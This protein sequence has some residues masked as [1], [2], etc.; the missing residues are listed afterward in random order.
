MDAAR[1]V[2]R[3]SFA[4]LWRLAEN[5]ESE[6]GIFEV[7]RLRALFN[8][9]LVLFTAALVC[10]SNCA[11]ARP[12]SLNAKLAHT[13]AMSHDLFRFDSPASVASWS[14]VDDRV[15]G[16][17]SQSRMRFDSIADA[18]GHA[19]FDGVVS[20]ER[21]G[22]FASVRASTKAPAVSA[23]THYV[24]EVRGDGKR[25]KLNL[26]MADTFDGVSYQASF[27]TV[28]DTW[29]FVALPISAFEPA[30]RGR[31]VVDAPPLDPAKVRQIGLMIA[32]K[33]VGR[34]ALAI[35]R[36]ALEVR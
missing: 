4:V 19:V 36:I 16:G 31:R 15:M 18:A 35:R 21:N 22:G 30:F 28:A 5:G 8:L 24:I 27:Q 6:P 29:A 33:Q 12:N 17:V 26:R 34:F 2:L 25:Y 11:N 23:A 32:D 14:P 1:V 9:R 7:I 10:M 13:A 3:E 20:L